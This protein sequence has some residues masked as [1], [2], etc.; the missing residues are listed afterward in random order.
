[1]GEAFSVSY[2]GGPSA[3][4]YRLSFLP[5][6][7]AKYPL[8]PRPQSRL[9]GLLPWRRAFVALRESD[10][11]RPP[12]AFHRGPIEAALG[13]QKA[14]SARHRHDPDTNS[15]PE[16]TR[17]PPHSEIAETR[18]RYPRMT[19]G[20]DQD[21]RSSHREPSGALVVPYWPLGLRDPD[22][23]TRRKAAWLAAACE[24]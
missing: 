11:A 6:G 23:C 4:A 10:S 20:A 3:V 5:T 15:R 9:R 13:C 1:M 18:A 22:P 24:G 14:G 21:L 12:R 8:G 16:E 2:D 19:G 17:D 7:S